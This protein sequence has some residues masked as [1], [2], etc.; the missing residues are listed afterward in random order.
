M[1]NINANDCL[2]EDKFQHKITGDI[3]EVQILEEDNEEYKYFVNLSN[4]HFTPVINLDE[5]NELDC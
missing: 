1:T 4:N 3:V 2:E 5:Y